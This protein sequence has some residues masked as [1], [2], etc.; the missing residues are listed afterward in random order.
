MMFSVCRGRWCEG[1]RLSE[2]AKRTECISVLAYRME[3]A[4]REIWVIAL[5]SLKLRR[6][7]DSKHRVD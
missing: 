7:W 3:R 2:G 6:V 1:R 4:H 5:T